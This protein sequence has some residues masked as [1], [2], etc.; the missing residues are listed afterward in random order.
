MGWLGKLLN[1]TPKEE[2][3]GIRLDT[4]LPF[5]EIEGKTT[6]AALL[7]ALADFLPDGCKS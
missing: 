4:A 5:W 7:R 2:L 6:F 3:D 1:A